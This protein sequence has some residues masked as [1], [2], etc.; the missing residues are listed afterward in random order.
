MAYVYLHTRLDTNDVF[1]VGISSKDDDFKRSRCKRLRSNYWKRITDKTQYRVDVVYRNISW[2]KACEIEIKLIKLY[3]RSDLGLGKLVNMTDGGE[4]LVGASEETIK[5]MSNA[6]KGNSNMLGKKHSDA[7]KAKLADA[8]RGKTQSEETRAKL[9]EANKG[10][11]PWNKG[12]EASEEAKQK[13]SESMKGKKLTEETKQKMSEKAKGKI[14]SEET[15]QKISENKKGKK[16]TEEH[17]AKLTIIGSGSDNG[18]FG[19]K[20]SEES[21]EKM[22]LARL[23]SIENKE[24]DGNKYSHS[25]ETKEKMRLA[26]LKNK[27]NNQPTLF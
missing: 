21:K 13:M 23:K 1:Y 2:E 26:K 6:A 7:T 18:F 27:L 11:V 9:S 3:G 24:N 20:H 16:L 15:K 10:K 19:K 4:G 22:R 17:K 12:K 8:A 14:L 5:K 25:E